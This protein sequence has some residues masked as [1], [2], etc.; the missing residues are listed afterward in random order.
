MPDEAIMSV[1]DAVSEALAE[2]GFTEPNTTGY[3]NMT[4]EEPEVPAEA[5]KETPPVATPVVDDDDPTAPTGLAPVEKTPAPTTTEPAKTPAAPA[6][7]AP[8]EDEE[9]RLSSD[10][11]KAIDDN[12]ELKKAYRGMVRA[13]STKSEKLSNKLKEAETAMRAVD[14][15]TADPVAALEVMAKAAGYQITKV[16][17][18]GAT[19]ATTTPAA[20]AP[21]PTLE[22]IKGKLEQ[23]IGKEAGDV[24][25]EAVHDIVKEL[26]TEFTTAP[27]EEVRA[28]IN[29]NK[30]NESRLAMGNAIKDYGA[31]I[32][33]SGRTWNKEV[34]TEMAKM[35]GKVLPNQGV[36][37]TDYL[38]ILYNNVQANFT[39]TRQTE[40]QVERIRTAARVDEPV[41]PTR[42]AAPTPQAI[43]AGMDPKLATKLAIEQARR[44]MS[45]RQ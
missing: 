14:T 16:G 17:Q 36:E 1:K 42:P 15:I 20:P 11:L 39:Q 30:D 44:E 26:V 3:G 6:V 28:I 22:R 45:G 4:N 34:E 27:I 31:K 37:F 5:A 8:K 24:L 33:E 21:A 7:T 29:H 18:P 12:P 41:R 40:Q 35:I 2:T 32:I 19:A 13:Y 23:R 38:D 43:V 10:E 9:F 25:G